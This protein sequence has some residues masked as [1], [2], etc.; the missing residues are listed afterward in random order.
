MGIFGGTFDPF[1][2]CHLTILEAFLEVTSF[3]K[4]HVIPAKIPAL[5]DSPESSAED[6]LV[7]ARL[8][9]K[10]LS[11]VV[12]DDREIQRPG[13]SYTIDT[14]R[15]LAIENV[16]Q[17]LI[18]ALGRDAFDQIESWADWE[19]I[20][21]LASLVV[22]NRPS[23]DYA[24]SPRWLPACARIVNS[25]DQCSKA[26]QVLFLKNKPCYG[27]A[28]KIRR[29]LKENLSIHHLVPS[30]VHEYIKS[31]NLYV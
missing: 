18:L 29:L 26:G 24:D 14:L 22:F 8:G 12:C 6:R 25:F 5:R 15:S 28:T 11:N 16:H 7:M 2:N 17:A 20:F 30:G 21:Q 27:S 9:T 4:V 3:A 1:H 19:E 23:S 13:T 10:G 31:R